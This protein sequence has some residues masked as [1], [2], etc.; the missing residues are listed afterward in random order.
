MVITK[1]TILYFSGTG[2]SLQ[3]SK[4]I[5]NKLWEFDLCNIASLVG[6]E[7]IRIE[8]KTL[9]IV[10]PVYYSRLPLVVEKVVKKLEI[11]KNTYIFGVA[12]HGGAPASVLIKLKN[13]LRENGATLNSGFLLKMPANNVLAY[14][15][16]SPEKYNKIFEEEKKK[17]N[18]IVD[19]IRERKDH[20]CEVS[21]LIL[22]IV[23]DKVFIKTTD[24]IMMG[25]HERDN[26]FWVN[27]SC[28]G[29]RLCE[30]VCPVNN[31]EF[32]KDKPIWK[33]KCEQCTACIQYC[34]KE[35]IQWGNGTVKRKRYRNPNVNINEIIRAN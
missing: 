25:F 35:A 18:G 27:D 2:N 33:H 1:D 20:E 10:F 31:I 16:K 17:V 3:V 26:K 9:G 22:D 23:I 29:C 32:N 8:S 6:E 34:P 11:N 7:K 14:N 28:N 12:A 21:K 15:T 30:K 24:K 19:V 13:I 4:D 5:S